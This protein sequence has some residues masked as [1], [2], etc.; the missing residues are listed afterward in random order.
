MKVVIDIPR[1][2]P[3][4]LKEW[5]RKRY[6]MQILNQARYRAKRDGLDFTITEEDIVLTTHCPILGIPLTRHE[7]QP[8][9]HDDSYSLDRIDNSKGY[10]KGNVRIISNRANRLKCD[11]TV[12]ELEKVLADARCHRL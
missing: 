5:R 3:D 4:Y 12:E 9:W 10:I 11:A 6:E 1:N 2:H 7:G 8:G